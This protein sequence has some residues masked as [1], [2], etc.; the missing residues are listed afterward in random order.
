MNING[1]DFSDMT[2]KNE[3]VIKDMIV[4][5]HRRGSCD[6][7]GASIKTEDGRFIAKPK[8]TSSVSKTYIHK[9]G[10]MVLRE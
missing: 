4:A 8:V 7:N 3:E 10:K 9:D 6:S 2:F 1:Y 5:A